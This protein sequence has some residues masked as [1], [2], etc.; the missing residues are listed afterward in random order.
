MSFG[1]YFHKLRRFLSKHSSEILTATSC[2]GV[3]ATGVLA[4][5]GGKDGNYIPA[6]GVGALTIGSIMMNHKVTNMQK[7]AL[8]AAASGA[9]KLLANYRDKVEEIYG[10]EA[11]KEVY[12]QVKIDEIMSPSVK[13]MPMRHNKAEELWLD[14]FSGRY[15]YATED[16]IDQA[17]IDINN[18]FKK[19]NGYATLNDLWSCIPDKNL[20]T[21]PIG[22]TIWW[23][24]LDMEYRDVGEIKF[25]KTKI[26]DDSGDECWLL[27]YEHEP[28]PVC[29]RTTQD[30]FDPSES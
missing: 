20:D 22:E 12:E 10:E 7:T 9:T 3:I 23:M 11:E 24:T 8:M 16:E 6:I 2:A 18:L 26:V 28:Y 17:E 5:K 1:K 29:E 13:E 4:A 25:I 27:E 19:Q 15:F 30:Y 14:V 21:A